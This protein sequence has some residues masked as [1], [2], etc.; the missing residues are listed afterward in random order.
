MKSLPPQL[1][2]RPRLNRHLERIFSY[3]LT[4]VHAPMGF[5]KTTAIR[6]FIRVN[7]L[8]PVFIPLMGSSSSL[9]YFWERLTT[10]VRKEDPELGSQL[11]GLG[12]PSDAP[13][14][15]KIIELLEDCA[16]TS[17]KFLFVDD[18]QLIDCPQA[19]ETLV[20]LASERI[21]NLHIVLLTREISCLP[22]E[23]LV[24]KQ[25]CWMVTQE[26]LQFRPEEV[27]SYFRMIN[28]P[29]SP[30]EVDRITRW[31]GGWISGIYLISRGLEQGIPDH[32][33]MLDQRN[34]SIDRL[35]ELN[36][37][38]AYDART[39]SFMEKLSFLDAFTPEQVAYVFDDQTAPAFLFSLVQGNAFLSYSRSDK[40]YRMTDL[41]REFLQRKARQNGFDP[42]E[43]YRR[44]G[45]WFL[46]RG[47]RILAYD[48]LYRGGDIETILET[49]NRGDCIDVHFTQFPQMHMIFEGLPEDL[50]FRY[51]LAA[52]QHI[53]VKA[54]TGDLRERQAMD[55]LLSR[56]E[57]HYL[58]ADMGEEERSRI[59]GEIHNTWVMAAFN[60]VRGMV[61][62]ASRAV[63]FFHGRYSCLISNETEFTYGATS[64][65]YSYYTVA[66][67]LADTVDFISRNFHILAQAVEGCGSGSESLILA[68]HAL[69]TGK[70]DAVTVNAYKAIYE[71]RLHRQVCIEL[72]A[73]FALCRLAI[74]QGRLS[75]AGRLLTQLATTVEAEHNSIFNTTLTVCTAYLDCCLGR[76]E[77]VPD[78]LRDRDQGRGSFMYRN[79]GFHDIVT[80]FTAMREKRYVQLAV[81]CDAF[82]QNWRTFSC[83]LGLI[84]NRVFRAIASHAIYGPDHG[85]AALCQA[86]DV[87]IQDGVVLPF[88]ECAAEVLP[89]LSHPAVQKRYTP[90]TLVAYIRCCQAYLAG[91]STKGQGQIQLSEREAE[92]LQLLSE[93]RSH[94]EIAAQL[95]ISVPTVRYH[96]KNIYQKL[97]VNNKV[98]ALTKAREIGL[99]K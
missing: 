46:D 58:Q 61:D 31:T 78:W 39:R 4:V 64:L 40:A 43:L 41:L 16:F 57:R 26:D 47:R 49:L 54:L 82:E 96:I 83:Q 6:E 50:F 72:C 21:Q 56:M 85:A 52:L 18:Y 24:Q 44:M 38:S 48:Y 14:T 94:S 91:L 86:L 90:D 89:I 30:Q 79:L 59:L 10:K 45:R 8:S 84:Y 35:L 12:F 70:F 15:A 33:E 77:R 19:A 42:T 99:L 2:A 75:E 67:G 9:A 80:C 98:S 87:A 1:L 65:L 71:S 51:P 29:L 60:D 34:G 66:G 63:S 20:S 17:P 3:P 81:Y 37:Y 27:D 13:Q 7:K 93:S 55:Q 73:T 62:H 69:E 95:Y 92:I 28:A 11:L 23:E 97:G 25:L 5:G 76:P 88:A 36:L 74:A 22:A 53:R 32:E 68:E